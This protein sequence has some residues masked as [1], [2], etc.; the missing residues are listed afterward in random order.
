MTPLRRLHGDERG[1]LASFLIKLVIGVALVGLIVIDTTA[2]VLNNVQTDDVA[3]AAANDAANAFDDS[4]SVQSA[5][6][7]ALQAIRE[8]GPDA[9]M[10]RLVVRTDG[11]V[12]VTVTNKAGTLLSQHVGFLDDFTV[13]RIRAVGRPSLSK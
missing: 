4:G 6:K 9:R 11:S 3:A 12:A 7:A 13:A 8:E 1:I 2:I 5:R 10:R